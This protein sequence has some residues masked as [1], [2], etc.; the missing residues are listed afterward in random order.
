MLAEEVKRRDEKIQELRTKLSRMEINLSET[1]FDNELV[2]RRADKSQAQ[3]KVR[4]TCLC[5]D[6]LTRLRK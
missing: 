2:K 1:Q 5:C 4:G 6:F 3:T